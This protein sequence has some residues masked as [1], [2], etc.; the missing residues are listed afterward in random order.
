MSSAETAMRVMDERNRLIGLVGGEYPI[1]PIT[2]TGFD[3]A[4]DTG[5]FVY[6][7]EGRRY[8]VTVKELAE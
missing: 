6:E 8:E 4:S 7:I 2:E 5:D 3:F 1:E